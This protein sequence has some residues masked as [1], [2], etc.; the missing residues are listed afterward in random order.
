VTYRFTHPSFNVKKIYLVRLDRALAPKDKAKLER[1]IDLD[2]KDTAPCLIKPKTK[3]TLEI[4]IS[5]GRKRQIRRMFLK[6]GYRVVDLKRLQE[7]NLRLGSLS[8]G[9]WKYL[10][11]RE[12][13]EGAK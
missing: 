7:G 12:V 13:S 11:E 6:K 3:T 9:K 8:K 4:T 1:G 5:E 10:S 2:G